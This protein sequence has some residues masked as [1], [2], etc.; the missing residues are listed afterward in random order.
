MKMLKVEFHRNKPQSIPLTYVV[1]A[2][3]HNGQWVLVRHK[4]RNTYEIPGGHIEPDEDYV[5]AA[6]RE[7]YEETGAKDFTLD[8]VSIYTV[9]TDGKTSGGYL[10][11]ADIRDFSTLPDYEMAEVVLM[12]QLPEN[13]TYPLIQPHLHNQV[14]NWMTGRRLEWKTTEE[15]EVLSQNKISWNAM[16]DGWSGTILPVWGCSCPAEDELRLMP[17]LTDKNVLEI[18]CG[19]GH[20]LK[21][22]GDKGASELWGLDISDNQLKLAETFLCDNNYESRLFNSP[23]EQNPG[24]PKDYFD[25]VYSVYAIGWTTDLQA[26]FNLILSY[27][28][29]DG[30]FIFSW[31][32]PFMHCVDETDG[33]LIFSGSYHEAEPFT[34]Q[35]HGN[36]LTLHNR[37]L[38]DYI[39]ALAKA[40]FAI[41]QVVEE[42]NKETL[43]RDAEF[44]S[45]YYSDTKAKQF[46]LSIIIKARKL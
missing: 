3:R 4:E 31:D 36:P 37:R 26:T 33:K 14:L 18:G 2:A 1:L 39:N 11:F 19:S 15:N 45:G 6:K 28:K 9:A 32:H 13:L 17:D 23:M 34:F 42:T 8:F 10:F 16:A 12:D 25:V 46:P 7:L 21:W 20:S 29:K 27:L 41:E 30:I 35:K 44:T 40:G 24:L 38:C 43:E 22:C 5:T